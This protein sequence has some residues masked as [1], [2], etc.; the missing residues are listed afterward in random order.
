MDGEGNASTQTEGSL[1][2]LVKK[3]VRYAL[4]CEYARVT[5]RREAVREKG[6]ARDPFTNCAHICKF[7]D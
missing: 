3:F 4:A 7:T 5:I 2:Q 1:E 6:M